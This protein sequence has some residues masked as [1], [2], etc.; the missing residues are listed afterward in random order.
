MLTGVRFF[1]QFHLLA[2]YLYVGTDKDE[3]KT[4]TNVH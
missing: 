4:H 1:L 2:S 3:A